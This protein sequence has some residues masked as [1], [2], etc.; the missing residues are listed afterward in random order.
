MDAK[1]ELPALSPAALLRVVGDL[2]GLLREERLVDRLLGVYLVAPPEGKDAHQPLE[3]LVDLGPELELEGVEPARAAP[4]PLARVIAGLRGRHP[5]LDL[6][7]RVG[8]G[9]LHPVSLR[10]QIGR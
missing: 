2:L 10:L 8:P 7:H 4:P 1:R 6:V 9:E 3:P 5:P